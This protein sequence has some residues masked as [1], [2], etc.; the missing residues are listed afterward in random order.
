ME[1][2]SGSSNI[3]FIDSAVEDCESLVA[4]VSAGAEVI[5]LDSEGDGVE[6][7]AEVLAN[8]TGISSVHIVSHGSPGTLQLGSARLSGDWG[9]TQVNCKS[10]GL[11][12]H[13]MPAS[14]Y[15]GAK[16]QLGRLVKPL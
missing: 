3:V 16:W 10:G 14:L 11:L 2:V 4:G 5:V 6:Q 1:T 12:W 9:N 8:R 13:Q 15:M 7:I